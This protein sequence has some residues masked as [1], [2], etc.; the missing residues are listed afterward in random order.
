M[1]KHVA[2]HLDPLDDSRDMTFLRLNYYFHLAQSLTAAGWTCSFIGLEKY[3]SRALESGSF[4]SVIGL[5]TIIYP[6]DWYGQYHLLAQN[7]ALP[8]TLTAAIDDAYASI[9]IDGEIIIT[10][11]PST[12]LR[13]KFPQALI[14]HYEYGMFSRTP[15]PR[16]HQLDPWGYSHKSLLSKYPALGLK[17]SQAHRDR[18]LEIRQQAITSAGLD[19]Q[20]IG[21]ENSIHMPLQSEKNW[22]IRL[23]TQL[24]RKDMIDQLMR[25]HP[26]KDIVITE[27]SGHGLAPEVRAALL[28]KR[29]IRLMQEDA[30]LSTGSFQTAYCHATYTTSPSLSLQTIA[31]GNQL[32]APPNSSMALWQMNDRTLAHETLASYIGNFS[33]YEPADLTRVISNGWTLHATHGAI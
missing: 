2:F 8:D 20:M 25:I 29:R 4:D 31:W 16:M 27:K 19:P 14:L 15:F 28:T 18:L 17:P 24:Q 13:R 23:E 7:H 1:K 21:Q 30:G 12:L 32:I 5:P 3:K 6:W 33:I 26:N 11:T 10:N 22:P 9:A